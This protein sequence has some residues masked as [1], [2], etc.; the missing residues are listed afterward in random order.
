VNRSAFL[1]LALLASSSSGAA[2]PP[3][4]GPAAG[5]PI[6]SAQASPRQALETFCFACDA[7]KERIPGALGVAERR[8]DFPPGT[9]AADRL[10]IA[11]MLGDLLSKYAE[12]F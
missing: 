4:T 5:P 9:P 7:L 10:Q 1:L 8:L 2:G 6:P 11:L 12:F 3:S